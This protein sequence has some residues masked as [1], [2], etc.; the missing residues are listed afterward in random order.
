MFKPTW[1]ANGK[2][3]TKRNV[4]FQFVQTADYNHYMCVYKDMDKDLAPCL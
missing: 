1:L 2:E 4:L 3:K